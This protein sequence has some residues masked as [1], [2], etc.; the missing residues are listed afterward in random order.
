MS[1]EVTFASLVRRIES[2]HEHFAAQATRAVNVGLTLRNWLIGGH[3]VEYEQQG[4]DRARYG[5]A[6][7]SRLST[8]L[9]ASGFVDYH[10]REL[11]RCRQFY[12]AYP[13]IRGTLSPELQPALPEQDPSAM[14][15]KLFVSRYQLALPGKEELE[16]FLDAELRGRSADGR[17]D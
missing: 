6:L 9:K 13:Q 4:E 16:G 7:F 17:G 15:N 14:D 11:R 3:I 2:V 5:E 10:P 12:Q 8:A 1:S